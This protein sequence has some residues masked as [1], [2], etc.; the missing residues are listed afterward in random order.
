MNSV[1]FEG[2]MVRKLP[3]NCGYDVSWVSGFTQ[4]PQKRVFEN[5]AQLDCFFVINK[6]SW[7]LWQKAKKELR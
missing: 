5:I 1:E 3:M 2:Y 4:I 6:Y 7:R